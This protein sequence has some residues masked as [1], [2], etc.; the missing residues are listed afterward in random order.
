MRRN[1]LA[2]ILFLATFISL[3]AVSGAFHAEFGGYPDEPAHYVTS[4][5]TY[6]Y[7]TGLNLTSPSQF[8][9]N[10]YDH[11]PKVAIGH[12]PPFFYAAQALWMIVFSPSRTSVLLELATTAALLAYAV[13][14]EARRWFGWNYAL[15]AG[16]LTVCL[17][18]VQLWA[19]EEMT[20]SL[21]ALLC[22]WS[23]IYL[24][25]YMDSERWQDSGRFA[26]FF[27]LA[28][29]TKGSGW[30][31]AALPPMALLLT[32][33]VRP[34]T[35]RSFWIS[36]PIVVA[37]CLPWQ[38]LTMHM[39]EE[40]WTEGARPRFKYMLL[41]LKKLLSLTA[42]DMGPVFSVLIA[43][44]ITGTV[45]TAFKRKQLDSS[46]AVMLSLV[47]VVWIFHSLVPA[48]V[49]DRRL[50][51]A[52]PGLVLFLFS[53]M[54]WLAGHLPV[55]KSLSFRRWTVLA[56]ATLLFFVFTFHIVRRTHYGYMD[57]AQYITS[58]PELRAATILVSSQTTGEGMLVSEIA[59][60]VPHPEG[61]ILRATK[62]LA[63]V[64]WAG[65]KYRSF[66]STP[67]QVVDYLDRRRVDLVVVDTLPPEIDFLHDKLLKQAI[68]ENPD[69]FR[70]LAI[71]PTAPGT[72]GGQVELLQV[73]P[74]RRTST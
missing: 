15:L 49:E 14:S 67:A 7:I 11:Y 72:S 18:L 25:R 44:G 6:E 17:P 42:R 26:F 27:S 5:M 58:H 45:L 32:R 65:S 29:L 47:L 66:F 21:L 2:F 60:R 16:L 64:S 30:L 23:A 38:L 41:G 10:Y 24:A 56:V 54:F 9:Q 31:L 63:E 70:V 33:R 3:Q 55:G 19:D 35:R 74:P 40:G 4:L 57:A 71:F 61:T 43:I 12:W 39:A 13:Y 62:S 51:I 36:I 52:V 22:F 8:A 68:S 28:V 1:V 53:G 20:E 48:W 59:M 73:L 50:L 34:F 37:L 46:R 69:R